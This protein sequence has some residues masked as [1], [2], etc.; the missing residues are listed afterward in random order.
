MY[1]ISGTEIKHVMLKKKMVFTISIA[2]YKEQ[3][4]WPSN[5]KVLGYHERNKTQNWKPSEELEAFV[6]KHSKIL[7]VTFGSMT[8][9]EPEEKTRIILDIIERNNIPT[10]INTAGGGLVIP[11]SYDQNLI[12]FVEQI[13]YDWAFPKMYAVMHHGGSGTTHLAV[14]HGCAAMIIPHIMDQHIWNDL[15]HRL[16]AGPKGIPVHKIKEA[17]LE[18]KILALF[19]EKSYKTNVEKLALEMNQENLMEE[20]CQTITE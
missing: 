20:L 5:V 18:P 14:K 11:D 7:F 16:G 8:N 6:N 10:L 19:N 17:N 9:P 13:P 1:G 2:F 4:Y 15:N 12:F 3:D